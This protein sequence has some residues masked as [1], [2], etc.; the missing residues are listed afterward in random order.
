VLCAAVRKD[1]LVQ[2]RIDHGLLRRNILRS[3]IDYA[4]LTTRIPVGATSLHDV[5]AI[6]N[7]LLF[8]P[9]V[10]KGASLATFVPPYQHG[11]YGLRYYRGFKQML[12]AGPAHCINGISLRQISLPQM[13]AA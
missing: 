11:E 4:S 3:A 9:T 8:L 2:C 1:R 10:G 5:E 12:A 7:A 6:G 13:N